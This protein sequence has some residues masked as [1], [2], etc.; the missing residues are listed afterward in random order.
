MS[1]AVFDIARVSTCAVAVAERRG[2]GL[3]NLSSVILPSD[4]PAVRGAG[5]THSVVIRQRERLPGG[6]S[7]AFR[8]QARPAESSARS[9]VS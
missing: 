7:I 5:A 3:P 6:L 1:A 2:P 8:E 4:P 9:Y